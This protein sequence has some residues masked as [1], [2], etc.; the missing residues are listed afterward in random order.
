MAMRVRRIGTQGLSPEYVNATGSSIHR[1]LIE[2]V[3]ADEVVATTEPV[4]ME[5][6]A[7][8]RS[9]AAEARHRRMLAPRCAGVKTGKGLCF[10][11]RK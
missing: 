11:I 8:S 5:V 4:I 2:L 9:D 1:R 6:V 3:E 10:Q 7:G